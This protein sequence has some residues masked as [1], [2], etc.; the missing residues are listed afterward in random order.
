MGRLAGSDPS[1][2]SDGYYMGTRTNIEFLS[3]AESL[4]FCWPTIV[5]PLIFIASLPVD[6]AVD[7]VLLPYDAIRTQ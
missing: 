2:P 3:A 1:L 6:A 5:C 7:T 4:M